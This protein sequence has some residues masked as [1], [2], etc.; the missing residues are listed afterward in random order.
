MATIA[1][2]LLRDFVITIAVAVAVENT[3]TV[4]FT[5][6]FDF[7]F[8]FAD[9]VP[10]AVNFAV[11][12]AIAVAIAV[13]FIIDINFV[14]LAWLPIRMRSYAFPGMSKVDST[15]KMQQLTVLCALTAAA[16]KKQSAVVSAHT[17]T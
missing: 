13:N 5:V 11:A 7:D 10:L 14:V 4:A 8:A 3:V 17:I 2:V 1:L 12:V 9:A 16:T 15:K 6:N